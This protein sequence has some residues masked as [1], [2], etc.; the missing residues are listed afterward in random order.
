MHLPIRYPASTVGKITSSANG[1][2][3]NT[4]KPVP[5]EL[6]IPTAV[7]LMTAITTPPKNEAR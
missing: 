2:M 6:K 4:P 1:T 7:K 5:G 3:K